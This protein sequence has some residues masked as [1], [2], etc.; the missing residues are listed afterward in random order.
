MLLH[1]MSALAIRVS[2]IR[3]SA[4]RIG[5]PG[6]RVPPLCCG[7]RWRLARCG[8]CAPIT[9][10]YPSHAV[11]DESVADAVTHVRDMRGIDY[12]H[13]A[14]SRVCHSVEQP[15]TGAEQDGNDIE[16]KLVDHARRE[17]LAHG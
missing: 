17:R 12:L 5:H 13:Q 6:S 10:G 15:L 11:A 16:H 9:S 8:K 14:E 4:P 7:N 1:R 3:P 2:I